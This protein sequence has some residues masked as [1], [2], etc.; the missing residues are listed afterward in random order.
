MYMGTGASADIRG[1]CLLHRFTCIYK[2]MAEGL[3]L[4]H[5]HVCNLPYELFM[6]LFGN[7]YCKYGSVHTYVPSMYVYM[8]PG[9]SPSRMPA[10]EEGFEAFYDWLRA[11]KAEFDKASRYNMCKY[12]HISM[13]INTKH[14]Q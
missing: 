11:G 1:L 7:E 2:Y 8:Y 5:V 6:I 4:E 3:Y 12:M 10:R 14:T 13:Y 9:P